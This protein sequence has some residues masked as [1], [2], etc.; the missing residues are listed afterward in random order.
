MRRVR[1]VQNTMVA[2]E[3]NSNPLP[4]GMGS[5]QEAMRL[6]GVPLA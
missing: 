4:L 1:S 6:I 5:R 3:G 2:R